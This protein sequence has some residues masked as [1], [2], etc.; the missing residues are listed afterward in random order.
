VA[1]N[2]YGLGQFV[3]KIS[4]SPF[5]K[6]SMILVLED[7]SQDGADHVD[8]HRMPALVISPYA[9]KGA[10]VHTRYDFPS[11]LRTMEIV[12]GMHPLTLNDAVAT[13][14]Y[15]AFSPSPANAEPYSAIPPT[16]DLT[17]QNPNTAANR[18]FARRYDLIHT[19]RVGQHALDKMLWRAVRGKHSK[20]PPPGPNAQREKPGEADADG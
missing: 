19:D 15:D 16:I 13:P 18:R 17:Q 8:A 10:V 6:Q 2:D 9:K 14:L 4:H 7:D 3:E 1:E 11:F 5:W 12:L 20:P